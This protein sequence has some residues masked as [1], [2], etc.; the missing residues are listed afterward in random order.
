MNRPP[1]VP[2]RPAAG[3]RSAFAQMFA[4]GV[5]GKALGFVR[6]IALAASFG[7]G[8]A[9]AAFRAAQTATT[10]PT[11][12]FSADTL[13]GGF[14]PLCTRYL[15]EDPQRARTLFWSVLLLMSGIGLAIA[16]L[17][18]AGASLWTALLVPGLNDAD[19]ALTAG[20]LRA[21]A[22]GVPFYVIASLT[23]YVEMASGR[24]FIGAVRAA[25]QNVG[26]IAGIG[27]A[28][29]TGNP[30]WLGRG[31]AIYAVLFAA[32]GLSS[33]VRCGL[34]GLP[35]RWD[36]VEARS[37]LREFTGIVRPLMLL[38]LVQ[39]G[40]L[41]VERVVASFHGAGA[42]ASLD[43]ARTIA[44]TG[45]ALLAV[46]L[47]MAGLSE[48][49][50]TGPDALR[51]RLERLLPAVLLVTVP[52]SI[53]LALN[54]GAIVRVLFAR[55]RFGE[56]SVALTSLI[57]LGFAVGF[58][59]QVGGHVLARAMVAG[60]RNREVA[61]VAAI[62]SCVH[63]AVN[64]VAFRALGP[65]ALGLAAS[66]S[67][68]VLLGLCVRA[69]GLGRVFARSLAPLAG[70]ALLYLP[71]GLALRG[72]ALPALLVSGAACVLCWLAVVQLAPGLRAVAADL[73]RRP[74]LGRV[75]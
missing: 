71:I 19:R 9:A 25:V 28:A 61:R 73:A 22:V 15:R 63:I 29:H 10:I 51:A 53:F 69:L 31:F 32:V 55:G 50:R 3:L 12:Y 4:G 66:A 49:S 46:P 68:L 2:V 6:E 37:V 56:D 47:G 16:S 11:H 43:Y 24:Y 21:M 17:L 59:A 48:L 65:L 42:I 72:D 23:S 7:T 40:A 64:L 52:I 57:L 27:A 41:A 13:N 60:S 34:A 5:L 62:A 20:M 74:A 38:P 14:I 8:P 33:V 18:F 26:L 58:W 75:R 54:A 35:A 70:G 36:W 39:L 30:L 44:E 45:L 1:P 67:A